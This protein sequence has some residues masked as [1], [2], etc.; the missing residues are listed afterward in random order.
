[1]NQN[2]AVHGKPRKFDAYLDEAVAAAAFGAFL[3]QARS[4][5]RPTG[6]SS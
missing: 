2:F 5:G 4:A 6:S 1:M 3:N